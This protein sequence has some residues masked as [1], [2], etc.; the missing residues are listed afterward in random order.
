[1]NKTA[2]VKVFTRLKATAAPVILGGIV[3]PTDGGSRAGAG[4]EVVCQTNVAVGVAPVD[5]V[6][7]RPICCAHWPDWK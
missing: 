3:V 1:M 4:L 6:A 7:T 5:S 2:K